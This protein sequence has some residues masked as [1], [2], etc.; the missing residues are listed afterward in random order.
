MPCLISASRDN[1]AEGTRGGQSPRLTG[2]RAGRLL[3]ARSTA[4][5]LAIGLLAGCAGSSAGPK[6]VAPAGTVITASATACGTGW[7]HPAAGVQTLQIHN[8]WTGALEVAL[9]DSDTGAIYARVEGIGP[10]MTQPMQ[11]DVG[12]GAYAFECSGINYADRVG[13][14]ILIAGHVRGGVGILPVSFNDMITVTSESRAYIVNGL[15]TLA[16]QT[17]VLA[18]EIR[19][20]DL[21]AA[22]ATWLTAHLTWERLGSAY[23]MFGPY[24]DEIDGLPFGLPGGVHDPGFTGFYRLEYGLWHSQSA[25]EL[26]GPA[27][28]LDLDARSL[29]TAYPGMQLP[30]PQA[31]GDLALRTHEILENAMRFQISGQA[32]F[33]SGTTLATTAAGIDATRAQLKMLYPL[34]VTRYNDLPALYSWLNRL[35][36][37]IDAEKTSRGWTPAAELTTAQ[38]EMIDAAAGQTLELLSPIPV[39]FEAERLIP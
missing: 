36:S 32:D 16:Q 23:G 5:F 6:A 31:L 2:Q 9:I 3:A 19:A 30:P 37:L 29:V 27:D 39:I 24:D 1:A 28:Q 25:A 26:T 38:R 18:A 10:G 8:A 34:L 14:T 7:R 4:T 11:V 35:Q 21:T 17:A 33:G 15:T 22:Q 12:S 20:G 13:R